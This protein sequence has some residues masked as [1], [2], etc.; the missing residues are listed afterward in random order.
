MISTP[1]PKGSI[2]I[3]AVFFMLVGSMLILAMLK[4]IYIAA[5]ESA[6]SQISMNQNDARDIR[7]KLK[8][9]RDAYS[10]VEGFSPSQPSPGNWDRPQ[11]LRP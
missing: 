3:A 2:L 6:P 4:M 10:S 7:S 11:T 5:R 1:S 8:F 9:S